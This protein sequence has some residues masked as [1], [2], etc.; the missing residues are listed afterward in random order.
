MELERCLRAEVE[1][2]WAVM[3]EVAPGA[4]RPQSWVSRAI[5]FL[6]GMVL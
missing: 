5:A 2:V 4:A 3:D 6:Q 1:K